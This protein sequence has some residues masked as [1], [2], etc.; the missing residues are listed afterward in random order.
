MNALPPPGSVVIIDHKSTSKEIEDGR[1]Y[2]RHLRLDHQVSNYLAGARALGYDPAGAIWDVIRKPRIERVLATP[3][4]E[5]KYTKPTK[6]EP[7]R[8]F[9]GQRVDD[10]PLDDYRERLR[11]DIE[12][13]PDAYYRRAFIVRTHEEEYAAACDAFDVAAQIDVA[14]ETGR[15]PRSV[16]ACERYFRLCDYWPVCTGEAGIE[17]DLLYRTTEAEHEE[18]EDDGKHHL[19]LITS[20]GMTTFQRCARE[21]FYAYVL[22]RKPISKAAA[23]DFGTVLHKGLEKWWETVDLNRVNAAIAHATEDEVMRVQIEELLRGYHARWIA[24]SYDVLAVE[25]QFRAPMIDPR[26]DGAS[27]RYELGGKIDAIARVGG[28]HP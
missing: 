18:L 13:H 7:A 11:E 3:E 25:K 9:K 1:P 15:F 26:T 14:R 28:D 22:G 17:S 5:R 10:E 21:Y 6:R 24:E 27:D 2:W 12:K 19:P 4:G 20:S 8:L 23:L 16:G